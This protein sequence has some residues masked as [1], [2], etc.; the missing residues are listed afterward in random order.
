MNKIKSAV[1]NLLIFV[2]LFGAISF[3]MD[4]WRRPN[5]P[6]NA[7]QQTLLA[8]NGE[9]VQLAKL[10]KEKAVL[11]YFWGSWCSICSLTSPSIASL[12]NEGVQVVSVA[13][14]SGNDQAVQDYLQQ[15]QY[16]FLTVND[17]QGLLSAQW[18][19]QVTPSIIIIK[20]GKIVHT[21][22]GLSSPW[23]LKL[24]LWLS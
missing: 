4:Y 14:K 15:H 7:L 19:I 11:L 18:H 24:R 22:T 6:E 12:A 10:S 16:N 9:S 13:L 3:A 20:N 1:K 2:L 17:P 21:T 5:A 8:L 23:G